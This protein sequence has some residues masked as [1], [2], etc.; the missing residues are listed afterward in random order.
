MKSFRVILKSEPYL[1]INLVI[2][3]IIVMIL[4]YSGIFTSEKDKYPIPCIH[5][6]ITGEECVSCGISHSFSLILR[7]R[8]EEAVKWNS[9]SP[10]VF[11]F[12][13]VQLLMR[14]A[15]SFL[16]LRLKNARP[17]LIGVDIAVSAVMFVIVFLPFMKYIVTSLKT[18]F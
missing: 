9:Y 13:A 5:E 18:F 2:A 16:Y 8:F 17:A 3:G 11:M 10:A 6:K 4:I 1:I 7:G 15:F 12:F 14:I